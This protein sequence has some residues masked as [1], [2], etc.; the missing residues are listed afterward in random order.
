MVHLL[1]ISDPAL[2]TVTKRA[3]EKL[4]KQADELLETAQKS[5][6]GVALKRFVWGSN[7]VVPKTR[8]PCFKP[9]G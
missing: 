3:R 9:I 8:S 5:P 7:K 2:K 4:L 6:Y 1:D